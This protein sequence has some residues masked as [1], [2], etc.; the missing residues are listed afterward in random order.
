MTRYCNTLHV[1]APQADWVGDNALA[2]CFGEGREADLQTFRSITHTRQGTEYCVMTT[3]VT[4]AVKQALQ[5]HQA[6][7]L[8]LPAP[9]WLTAEQVAAAGAALNSA[10]VLLAFDP[11]NKPAYSGQTIIALNC[12]RSAIETSYEFAHVTAD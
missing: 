10:L 2:A 9:P 4:D 6:G 12:D 11:D 7:A 8:T 5:A 3:S 1:F